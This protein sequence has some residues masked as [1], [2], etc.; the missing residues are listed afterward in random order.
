MAILVL[1]VHSNA[2]NYEF[3]IDLE[4]VIFTL[5]FSYNTR[6]GRW[7]MSILDS[8]AEILYVGDIP[9]LINLALHDQYIIP[10]LP[11]G[12]FIAIDETGQNNEATR[13]TFGNE[14]KLLYEEAI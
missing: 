13:E 9:I 7:H 1:P 10:E 8:T 5:E 14:I 2:P 6:S 3:Q 12:R 11:L 4:G